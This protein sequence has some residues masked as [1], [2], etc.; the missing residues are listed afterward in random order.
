MEFRLR[1]F[2]ITPG[3]EPF[4]ES[5]ALSGAVMSW[6]R[7]LA[8]ALH[9]YVVAKIEQRAR[10]ATGG[11]VQIENFVLHLSTLTA[12]ACGITL[13]GTEPTSSPPLVRADQLTV[14]LKILSL[15]RRKVNLNQIILR[16]P[17]VNLLVGKDGTTNLPSPPRKRTDSSTSVFDRG[18]QHFLLTNGEIYYHDVKRPLDLELHDVKLEIKSELASN[19]YDGTISYRNGH[20]QYCDAKPLAHDLHASF[21]ASPSEFMLKPLVLTIASSII[22]LEGNVRNYSGP[23]TDATYKITIHT[24]DSQSVLKIPSIPPGT[25]TL[26][27]SLR[28]EPPKSA[29]GESRGDSKPDQS[30]L[31]RDFEREIPV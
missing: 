14:R 3:D 22:Q 20:L 24:Q 2:H 8:I 9:D 10:A 6:K 1:P 30:L 11:C 18:I 13:R 4:A 5:G 19:R 26:A 31:L 23:V 25:I 21:N 7:K 28:Y 27:G 12:D 17:V 15:W 16:H 29:G